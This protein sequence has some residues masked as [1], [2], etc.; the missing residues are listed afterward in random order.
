MSD[1][2]HLKYGRR[3]SWRN[4]LAWAIPLGGYSL[5]WGPA[6]IDDEKRSKY[7]ESDKHKV[8]NQKRSHPSKSVLAR[9][10]AFGF[11]CS[12]TNLTF[13]VQLSLEVEFHWV[14]EK[15]PLD[16]ILGID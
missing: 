12:S 4:F 6:L 3:T 5:N 2:L 13:P 8:G 15:G 14:P 1:P 16:R 7:N 11:S 9:T 10:S